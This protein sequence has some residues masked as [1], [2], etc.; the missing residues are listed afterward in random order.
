MLTFGD[1]E[2]PEDGDSAGK[3]MFAKLL[4]TAAM[5]SGLAEFAAIRDAGRKN[6]LEPGAPEMRG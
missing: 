3:R 6:C 4:R 2:G 5:D 1:V